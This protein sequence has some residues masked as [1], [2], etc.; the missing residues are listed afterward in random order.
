MAPYFETVKS[1]AD[2]PITDAGVDTLAFL[3]ASQGVLGLFNAPAFVFVQEDI[4]GNIQKI[5]ARYNAAPTLSATLEQ[6][7]ENEKTE[8][9]R[10]ATQGLMWLLRGLSFTCKALQYLQTNETVTPAAAFQKSYGDTLQKFHSIFVRTAFS[11]AMKACPARKEFY[12]QLDPE[13]GSPE[14]QQ[15]LD[16]ALNK[17]LVALTAIVQRVEKFYKDGKHGEGF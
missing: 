5:R 13:R 2:V 12:D 1:F 4:K 10:T 11:L 16:E 9:K 6:L 14:L 3:E 17:W 7:V 15:K 8:K